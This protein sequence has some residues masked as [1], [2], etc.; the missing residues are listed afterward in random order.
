VYLA[1]LTLLVTSPYT[2]VPESP[3]KGG[4]MSSVNT[5]LNYGQPIDKVITSILNSPS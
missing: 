4:N 2:W 5:S 1:L 3:D